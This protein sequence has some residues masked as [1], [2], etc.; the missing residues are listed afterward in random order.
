MPRC[1]QAA[2]EPVHGR[3]YVRVTR[4]HGVRMTAQVIIQ[5]VQAHVVVGVDGDQRLLGFLHLEIRQ[6][7]AQVRDDA[8]T[9]HG[10]RLWTAHDESGRRMV[11]RR[12]GGGGAGEPSAVLRT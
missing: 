6:R 8:G 1:M 2:E 11:L 3:R 4:D 10:R 12:T 5:P 7:P 9:D